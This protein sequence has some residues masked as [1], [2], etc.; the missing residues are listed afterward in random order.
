MAGIKNLD[1]IND[2]SI[3][4]ISIFSSYSYIADKHK[5]SDRSHSST[6]SQISRVSIQHGIER[7]QRDSVRVSTRR[8]YESVWRTFNKFFV[9]LDEKPSTWED[10]LILFVGHLIEQNK[11]IANSKELRLCYQMHITM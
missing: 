9:R 10:R 8:I 1:K 3:R 11:K 4:T 5:S 7:L 2:M 6:S